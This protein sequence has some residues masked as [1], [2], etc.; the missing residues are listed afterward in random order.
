MCVAAFADR[1]LSRMRGLMGR[2]AMPTGSGG[3]MVSPAPA[4]HTAFMRFAIDAVFLDGE[5]E[6]LKITEQLGPWRVASKRRAHSVLELPAGACAE[7]GIAV[8]DKLAVC[9]EEEADGAQPG[10]GPNHEGTAA[11]AGAVEPGAAD[12]P[13]AGLRVVLASTDSHFR[14]V[15]SVL[16]RRRDC[17]VAATGNAARIGD[18]V[19]R[20]G[21]DVVV[22][23]CGGLPAVAVEGLP[24][25]VGVVFV[26]DGDAPTGGET[27]AL[28]KWGPFPDFVAAIEHASHREPRVAP[29]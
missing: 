7:L 19:A 20:V 26:T 28:S 23:D 17:T 1:P 12:S 21:A 27:P 14:S 13:H 11:D 24:N 25:D 29:S 3:L 8:G 16:L 4:I 6:V 22:L 15:T 10:D 9:E 5:L 18:L 2:R